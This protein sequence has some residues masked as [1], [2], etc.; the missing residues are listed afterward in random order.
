VGAVYE[1]R[2]YGRFVIIQWTV[3]DRSHAIGRAV[4]L[5]PGSFFSRFMWHLDR[6]A[7]EVFSWQFGFPADSHFTKCLIYFVYPL[8]VHWAIRVYVPRDPSNIT[9]FTEQCRALIGK[10]IV[11]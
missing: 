8:I 4:N 6:V 11:V 5:R 9:N 7:L 1:D 2:D 3:S 10:L